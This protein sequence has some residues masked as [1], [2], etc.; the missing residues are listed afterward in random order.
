MYKKTFKAL[1]I[2]FFASG[3]AV[4]I[5]GAF[6]GL[7]HW[8]ILQNSDPVL[9]TIVN[10]HTVRVRDTSNTGGPPQY[11]YRSIVYVEYEIENRTINAHLGWYYTGMQVGNTVG[12]FVSR[13]NPYFFVL[14]G[15]EGWLPA[16]ISAFIGIIFFSTGSGFLIYQKRKEKLR[17]WLLHNGTMIWADV[18]GIEKKWCMFINGRPATVLVAKYND[19]RFTSDPLSKKELQEINKN[20][21]IWIHPEIPNKY[22]FDF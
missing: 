8:S 9:A 12:I 16:I 15:V 11:R 4:M 17:D 18:V 5:F 20:V 1:G 10:I 6:I 13:D 3:L 21:K 19:M 7:R 2:A 22:F 14:D